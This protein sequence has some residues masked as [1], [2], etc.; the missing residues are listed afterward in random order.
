MKTLVSL[1]TIS[2]M[3]VILQITKASLNWGDVHI[4][5]TIK[6]SKLNDVANNMGCSMPIKLISK[7]EILLKDKFLISK[8]LL[9][10]EC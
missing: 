8:L 4:A 3:L 7:Q 9:A 1:M 2:A 6:T 10:Q 5:P